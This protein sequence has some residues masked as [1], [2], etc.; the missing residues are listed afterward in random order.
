MVPMCCAFYHAGITI[1]T[2]THCICTGTNVLTYD[3]GDL[4]ALGGLL[5]DVLGGDGERG[6][7]MGVGDEGWRCMVRQRACEYACAHLV[8]TEKVGRMMSDAH[9]AHRERMGLDDEGLAGD[10]D[11]LV[12]ETPQFLYQADDVVMERSI[13]TP[14]LHYEARLGLPGQAGRAAR[15]EDAAG[16]GKGVAEA[17]EQ[18]M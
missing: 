4:D 9:A 2:N 3:A 1:H 16:M 12:I 15:G 10:L 5:D 18:V 11:D 13:E 14:A 8:A 6:K 7:E 17:S